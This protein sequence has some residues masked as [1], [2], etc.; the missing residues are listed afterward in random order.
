MKISIKNFFLITFILLEF[1]SMMAFASAEKN[2]IYSTPGSELLRPRISL[3]FTIARARDCEGFGFCRWTLEVSNGKINTGNGTMY[4][5]EY[6]RNVILE[7]D[8]AKGITADCYK[9]YFSTGTFLMEDDSPLPGEVVKAL[10]LIGTKTLIAGK[11][12]IIES[13]GLLVITIP[14][15]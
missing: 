3:S 13:N 7:I 10:G 6:S 1:F 9:K 8:K 14:V 4:S 12:R 2:Q 11:H 15:K 5:D